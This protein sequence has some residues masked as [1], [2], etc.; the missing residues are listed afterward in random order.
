M[1][2]E[3]MNLIRFGKDS[4][5]NFLVVNTL[6][7]DNGKKIIEGSCERNQIVLGNPSRTHDYR[8]RMVCLPLES[9][10]FDLDYDEY[11]VENPRDIFNRYKSIHPDEISEETFGKKTHVVLKYGNVTL[12]V[13]KSTGI[14]DE[15]SETFDGIINSDFYTLRSINQLKDAHME[16]KG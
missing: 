9:Q 8:R 6:F 14:L 1:V 13:D 11:Y 3:L 5:G 4:E 16:R 15:V 10:I 2:V 12:K 7:I